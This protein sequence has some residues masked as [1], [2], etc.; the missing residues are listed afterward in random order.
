MRYMR[1]IEYPSAP[2][3]EF[4]RSETILALNGLIL[5]ELAVDKYAGMFPVFALLSQQDFF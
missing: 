5:T 3:C 2:A 1:D 4:H